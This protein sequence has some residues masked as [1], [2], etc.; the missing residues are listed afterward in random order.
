[1]AE[2]ELKY[3]KY[4]QNKW[5]PELE[6]KYENYHQNKLPNSNLTYAERKE[7]QLYFTKCLLKIG[8]CHCCTKI[9]LTKELKVTPK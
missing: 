2:L 8:V 3:E 1:V 4:H 6:L 7:K 9:H 5:H